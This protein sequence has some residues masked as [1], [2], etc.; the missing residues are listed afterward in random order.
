MS[1][2]ATT[3][4]GSASVLAPGAA[5]S[6]TL[7]ADLRI[8][9]EVPYAFARDHHVLVARL[10]EGD[11]DGRH[12]APRTVYIGP[13]TSPLAIAELQRALDRADRTGREQGAAR[14]V[15][16]PDQ[17]QR[18]RVQPRSAPM[19]RPDM[20]MHQAPLVL[21]QYIKKRNGGSGAMPSQ[22]NGTSAAA[23]RSRGSGP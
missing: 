3:R 23:V 7:P 13:S 11:A 9:R 8:A 2:V 14:P 6:A 16:R 15:P 10:D 19:L 4:F 5:S 18:G 17:P 12:A 1:T 20:D 21:P 22:L